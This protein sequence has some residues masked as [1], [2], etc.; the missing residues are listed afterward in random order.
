[1]R[2]QDVELHNVC[3]VVADK[4]TDGL[5][6]SRLPLAILPHVNEGVQRHAFLTAGCEIR[7]ML[8]PGGEARIVLQVDDGNV[9][10]PLVET[11]HGCIRGATTL[12]SRTPTE[13][14]I[15]RPGQA[16]H[17]AAIHVKGHYPFDASLV[18]V[19]LPHIHPCRIISIEGDLTYPESGSLPTRTMLAYGSSIT[20]GAHAV[21]PSGTYA[22]QTARRLGVDLINLGFG[23][24]AQMDAAIADHIAARDDW[25]FATLEMGINVRNWPTEKFRAA[26][27]YFVATIVAAHPDKFVFCM[28]LFTNDADFTGN[29]TQ[30]VGFREGVEEIAAKQNSARVVYVDGRDILTDPRGLQTDLVHPSD[31]GMQ[32]MGRN[33]AALVARHQ[34][35]SST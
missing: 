15:Q 29:K 25:D 3:D 18:R 19:S 28:D 4:G 20:N 6:L 17:I 22:S 8:R 33:L 32:E 5:R 27:E 34:H 35:I 11:F 31:Y 10:P 14:K 2:Y 24:A 13:I 23:G 1:M 16:E 9:V 21:L 12:L 7:G 30:A 26:V